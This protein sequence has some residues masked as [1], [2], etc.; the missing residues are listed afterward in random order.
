VYEPKPLLIERNAPKISRDE[1]GECVKDSH[2]FMM[3][4][5]ALVL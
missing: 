4:F 2:T 5:A 1:H 3:M